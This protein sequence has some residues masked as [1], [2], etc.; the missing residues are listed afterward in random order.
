MW[1]RHV[2]FRNPKPRKCSSCP[3]KAGPCCRYY[4]RVD[5]GG[6]GWHPH[7]QKESAVSTTGQPA[8]DD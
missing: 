8:C 7:S 2:G 4:R 6:A 5:P 1:R 3:G